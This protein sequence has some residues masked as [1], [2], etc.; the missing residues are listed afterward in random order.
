MAADLTRA[1]GRRFWTSTASPARLESFSR[2][3]GSP[4]EREGLFMMKQL[5]EPAQ[6]R[7]VQD[8]VLRLLDAVEQKALGRAQRGTFRDFQEETQTRLTNLLRARPALRPALF[9]ALRR[10]PLVQGLS[11]HP[12]LLAVLKAIGVACPVERVSSLQ[13]FLPWEE[14][15]R[16]RPHQDFGDMLSEHSWTIQIP[17]HGIIR[18]VTGAAEI[19]PGTYQLGPLT[20]HLIQD[21]RNRSWYE[22]TEEQWWKGRLLKHFNTE[23]GDAVFFRCLNIH[24]T[25]P[26]QQRIRWSMVI[27]YD[28]AAEAPIL[29]TGANPFDKLRA[30][31]FKIWSDQLQTFFTQYH[32]PGKPAA[33]KEARPQ[34]A[35]AR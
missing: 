5:I 13:V 19:Y 28:D 1:A 15:F 20:H 21:P 18:E 14:L 12:K 23:E 25:Y 17:L 7:A 32:V 34:A 33:R 24:Q 8:Q 2:F 11:S 3:A 10:L 6:L 26:T 4:C 29:R 22:T 16:E 31:D 35:P 30:Y 27:R 9:Q